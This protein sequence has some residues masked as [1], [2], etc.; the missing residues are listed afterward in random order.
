[1]NQIYCYTI[2]II[3]L[4]M[5]SEANN[6]ART[7]TIIPSPDDELITILDLQEEILRHIATFLNFQSIK[8]FRLVSREWNAAGLP[9]LMKRGYYNLIHSSYGVERPDLLKA[10]IHYSSWKINHSVYE[11]AEFL[12]DN[13][14]WEEVSSL[15]I[16]QPSPLTKPVLV[17]AWETISESRCP[18]LREL[19]LSFV[20]V[21]YPSA[22]DSEVESDT[23]QAIQGITNESFPT[24]SNFTNLTSLRFKGIYDNT[25]AY[26]AQHLLAATTTSKLRH[27]HFRPIGE[28]R[29]NKYLDGGEAYRVFDYLK[30]NP[31]LLSNLQSF[32]FNLTGRYAKPDGIG[33]DAGLYF[34]ESS[35]TKFLKGNVD[36]LPSF[37]LSRNLATL[38]W[39]PPFH[40]DGQ[41]L[42][43]LLSPSVSASLVQLSLQGR[44]ESLEEG[45]DNRHVDLVKLSFPNFP[46]LRVL[47]LGVLACCSLS[48]P[49]L[50]DCAPNLYVLEMKE[51]KL[52]AYKDG[53]SSVWHGADE[54]GSV[55]SP[56]QHLQLRMFCT[57][58]PFRDG[59]S[60]LQ[61]IS[62]KFPNLVE[63][64]LGSVEDVD[65]DSFLSLLASNAPGLE[66]LSWKFVG[67]F[68]LDELLG[69]VSR[70][71]DQ[72]PSLTS[73]SFGYRKCIERIRCS[74]EELEVSANRLLCL[75]SSPS[76]N[77]LIINLLLKFVSCGCAPAEQEEA[78]RN[79]GCKQCYLHEFIRK[80]ALPIR[81]PSTQE[82][83]EMEWGSSFC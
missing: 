10:A 42:P 32:G 73:Y 70:V 12:H 67:V 65:F 44:V 48:V 57:D 71:P 7:A 26:F 8:N 76:I 81:I 9:I 37:K 45:T 35:F 55:P 60:T 62:S 54:E 18:N 4:R 39:D 41:L 78:V 22:V 64:R 43:G 61:M 33:P 25:T 14:M 31:A 16:H 46:R 49:D 6:K 75:L 34:R 38:F 74:M 19:T 79:N 17:W 20:T 5:E 63:L 59:L 27:L 21:P 58:I 13:E 72:L 82:I 56:S 2:H 11:S 28:S 68:T 40:L 15:S 1:M 66:R 51:M 83:E 77:V 47:K 23:E 53:M 36:S 30:R 52:I 24:I 50:V 29:Y 69:H 80:H 3:N